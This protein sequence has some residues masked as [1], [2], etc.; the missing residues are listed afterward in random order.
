MSLHCYNP[1]DTAHF[2]GILTASTSLMDVR[3]CDISVND[4]PHPI[5]PYQQHSLVKRKGSM[6]HNTLKRI[7]L[8]LTS[9]MHQV[10]EQL[11]HQG[12]IVL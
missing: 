1:C 9:D 12:F 7:S 4:S 8:F 2:S 11:Y 6:K 10:S 3:T 5:A